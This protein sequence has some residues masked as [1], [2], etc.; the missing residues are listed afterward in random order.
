[1]SVPTKRP[2]RDVE[3]LFLCGLASMGTSLEQALG[4]TDRVRHVVAEKP[5]KS[6]LK[7]RLTKLE[8]E[9]GIPAWIGELRHLRTL[10]CGGS[11]K[12]LPESL[13]TLPHLRNLSLDGTQLVSL[14]G[15]ERL[16]ALEWL[17][18]G[19][20]PIAEKEGALE[21]L[22]EK[23]GAEAHESLRLELKRARPA[24]PKAKSAPRIHLDVTPDRRKELKKSPNWKKTHLKGAKIDKTTVV[25]Y[26]A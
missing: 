5:A 3:L 8:I 26:A 2:E 11:F 14:D 15:I 7:M 12:K 17:T 22:A 10:Q 1:M 23:L 25:E 20:T 19:D 13:F 16:P 18:V 24:A 21:A 4:C 9:D 6:M